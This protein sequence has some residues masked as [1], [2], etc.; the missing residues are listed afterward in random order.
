M[1]EKAGDSISGQTPI[2]CFFLTA[3]M[4]LVV[5]IAFY[6]T[7][8]LLPSPAWARNLKLLYEVGAACVN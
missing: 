7:L 6:E 4:L 1:H 2:M 3:L 8:R 5:G